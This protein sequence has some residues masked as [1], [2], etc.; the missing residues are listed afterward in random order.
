MDR[1]AHC[2]PV[3]RK[4]SLRFGGRAGMKAKETRCGSGQF[5]TDLF[6]ALGCF[7]LSQGGGGFAVSNEISQRKIR[8]AI[9]DDDQDMH[10]LIRDTLCATDDLHYAGGFSNAAA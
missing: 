4:M 9:V 5:F 7:R 10:L 1:A 2:L 3:Y 6:I 8:V